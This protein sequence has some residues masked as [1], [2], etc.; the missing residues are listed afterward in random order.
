MINPHHHPNLMFPLPS[1]AH[2]YRKGKRL[3]VVNTSHLYT[4]TLKYG[5]KS[6]CEKKLEV[7][8]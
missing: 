4:V 7:T 5:T 1:E 8:R 6:A 3:S 2:L